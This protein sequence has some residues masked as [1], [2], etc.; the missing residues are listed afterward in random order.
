MSGWV[1]GCFSRRVFGC[2]TGNG[3]PGSCGESVFMSREI[4]YR[5]AVVVL[6]QRSVR[7]ERISKHDVRLGPKRG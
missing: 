7:I 3:G 2:D 6:L 4:L 1:Y 5:V